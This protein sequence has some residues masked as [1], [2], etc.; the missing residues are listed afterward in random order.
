MFKYILIFIL[1]NSLQSS[2][3]ETN[4]FSGKITPFIIY[5]TSGSIRCKGFT[6]NN[7]MIDTV[8]HYTEE[9]KPLMY[10]VFQI[11]N[12]SNKAFVYYQIK[13]NK[14]KHNTSYLVNTGDN[15]FSKDGIYKFYR[16]DGTLMDSIIYKNNK[17]YYLA[18]FNTKGK[19]KFEKKY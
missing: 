8:W 9:G 1:F 6:L 3:Q 13:E 17:K 18:R 5:Y 11:N 19:I 15:H 2:A 12:G 7:N 4:E 16:N 10:E 14:I